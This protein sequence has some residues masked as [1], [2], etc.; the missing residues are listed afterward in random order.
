MSVGCTSDQQ[1]H[2]AIP[3]KSETHNLMEFAYQ[4]ILSL[5][6]SKN[7]MPGD[8]I[9][10]AKISKSLNISRTPVR[11]A[12]RRL[13][14]EGLVYI[15][16][17]RFAQ[18]AQYDFD[19]IKEICALRIVY[20]QLAVKLALL[21]GSQSEFSELLKIANQCL[22]ASQSECNA[23]EYSLLDCDFHME[24]AKIS[25]NELLMRF[26]NELY[27]RVQYLIF[28]YDFHTYNTQLQAQQHIE[29]AECLVKQEKDRAL[30]LVEQHLLNFYSLTDYFPEGFF[31]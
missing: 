13:S 11:E 10:E 9:S 22:A 21:F 14:N 5:I 23:K 7:L 19:K 6:F 29:I 26:Q 18:M 3:L 28:H 25:K 16:P 12:I 27:L 20:D 24:L 31:K 15:F 17:N 2:G 8:K 30:K 4:H 1:M